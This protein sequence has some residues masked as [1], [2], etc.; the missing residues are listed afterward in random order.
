[1]CD[2][3]ACIHVHIKIYKKKLGIIVY[4]VINLFEVYIK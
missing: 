4:I 2:F 3:L 1:M